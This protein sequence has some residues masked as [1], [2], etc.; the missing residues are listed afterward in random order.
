MPQTVKNGDQNWE[1]RTSKNGLNANKE[2][3]EEQTSFEQTTLDTMWKPKQ[4]GSKRL[5]F[6]M[7]KVKKILKGYVWK[8]S[9]FRL[10]ICVESMVIRI[11][12]QL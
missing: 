10:G 6:E 4:I 1:R 8:R 12:S 9:V 2:E 7:I 3:E 5:T 11:G